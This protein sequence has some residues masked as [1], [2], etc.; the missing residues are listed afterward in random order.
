MMIT[1]TAHDALERAQDVKAVDVGH[2]NPTTPSKPS[3]R[4]SA[5][6][7]CWFGTTTRLA[8]QRPAPTLNPSS[9]S[10]SRT[11]TAL[12]RETLSC[13]VVY[14]IPP[15][16]EGIDS[17][18]SM[19]R[20]RQ[21]D[22]SA[23]SCICTD[24][25]T[26][27]GPRRTSRRVRDVVS[28]VAGG[29]TKSYAAGEAELRRRR[30]SGGLLDAAVRRTAGGPPRHVRRVQSRFGTSPGLWLTSAVAD[31]HHRGTRADLDPD[32]AKANM[33]SLIGQGLRTPP[34]HAA[35]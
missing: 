30:G 34:P 24:R 32:A 16:A 28:G 3:T 35:A 11:C 23:N 7:P 1:G 12:M 10:T 31:R 26:P 20:R 29:W 15:A 6:A 5:S 2:R 14:D 13:L 17:H 21:R 4:C 19:M 27:D 33:I 18:C 25:R 9:S 8:E 22:T